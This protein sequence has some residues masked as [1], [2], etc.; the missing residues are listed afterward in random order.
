MNLVWWHIIRLA[1]LLQ[2]SS[3]GT[4]CSR[5]PLAALLLR[6]SSRRWEANLWQNASITEQEIEGIST[7]M[8]ESS[9][10]RISLLYN[11]PEHDMAAQRRLYFTLAAG[12][13]IHFIRRPSVSR[14][15]YVQVLCIFVSIEILLDIIGHIDRFDR[16]LISPW[17]SSWLGSF[18]IHLEDRLHFFLN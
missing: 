12:K 11:P 4:T 9:A 10:G 6:N 5:A 8:R 15:E 2:H 16:L 3:L 13:L 18:G 1:R 14:Q 7:W 17:S